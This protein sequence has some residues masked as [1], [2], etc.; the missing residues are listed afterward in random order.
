MSPSNAEI[1]RRST[2]AYNRGDLDGFMEGWAPDAE[3][4]WS[5]S[6]G[7]EAGVYRGHDEVRALTRRFLE[8]FDEVR[9]ELDDPI[10]IEDDLLVVENTTYLPRTRRR[11]S[12]GTKRMAD[13]L[14]W[15]KANLADALSDE[16][17]RPRSRRAVGV[18]DVAG[19]RGGCTPAHRSESPPAP[20]P[21]RAHLLALPVGCDIRDPSGLA[22]APTVPST[23]GGHPSR[24][25]D[26]LRC[27]Q[28]RRFQSGFLL[29]PPDVE[30]IT[31]PRF[32]AL[33]FDPVYRGREARFDFQR[34]WT[35]E[36]GE[37][38][39]EPDEMIDLG[40]RVLFV[41]RVKGSGVSSGA[42]FETQW[43]VL[44]TLSGGRLIREQPFFDRGEAL[45]A[46]GL[47]E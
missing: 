7:F 35:A 11:R 22:A 37:M 46:A 4:D 2:D 8:A 23:T 18:G 24:R 31:P 12:P 14:P 27:D 32:V 26:R 33:G 16:A 42:A 30:F 1:V 47:S 20:W 39:F 5:N 45:A 41:G 36:W 9:I 15:R 17:R 40:D 10:E 29:Y 19:E 21:G 44:C 28:S 3:L 25:A 13:R 6:G 43:A 34:R 38:R